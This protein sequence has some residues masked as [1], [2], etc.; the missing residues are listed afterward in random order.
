MYEVDENFSSMPGKSPAVII[1][2]FTC[3][4]SSFF[5]ITFKKKS[6]LQT[7]IKW[8]ASEEIN[9]QIPREH[10]SKKYYF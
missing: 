2:S 6:I 10:I 7:L 9:A 3:L 5:P 8:F 4:E 1:Q